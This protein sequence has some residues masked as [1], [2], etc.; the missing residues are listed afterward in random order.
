MDL[1]KICCGQWINL[2]FS[3]RDQGLAVGAMPAVAERLTQFF[4]AVWKALPPSERGKYLFLFEKE[5]RKKKSL[6][7]F[8]FCSKK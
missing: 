3:P 6:M 7:G 1:S 4:P 2:I 5:K 8:K